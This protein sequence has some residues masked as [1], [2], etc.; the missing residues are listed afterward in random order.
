VVESELIS[1]LGPKKA[2]FTCALYLQ[3]ILIDEATAS[4]DVETDTLI[5]AQ[6]RKPSRAA[7]GWSS[8]TTSPPSSAVTHSCS[9]AKRK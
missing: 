9:W 5:Q 3:I 2:A 7:H 6:S 8:L 4:I 1:G